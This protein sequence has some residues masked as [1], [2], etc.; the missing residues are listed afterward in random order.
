MELGRI[1]GG[2]KSGL[3]SDPVD[4]DPVVLRGIDCFMII[5][6]RRGGSRWLPWK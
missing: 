5:S 1:A 2:H 6:D 4:F 3:Y